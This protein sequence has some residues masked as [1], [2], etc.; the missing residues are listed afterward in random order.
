M[1]AFRE[2]YESK[3]S[4]AEK[5]ENQK[6]WQYTSEKMQLFEIWEYFSFTITIEMQT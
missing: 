3:H 2:F 4:L 6:D 1:L 5:W